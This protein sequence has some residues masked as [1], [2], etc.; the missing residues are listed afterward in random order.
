MSRISQWMS[1]ICQCVT[2]SARRPMRSRRLATALALLLSAITLLP[3]AAR[4][5][6]TD[7]PASCTTTAGFNEDTATAGQLST[8]GILKVPL[9]STT[10]LPGGGTLYTFDVAAGLV[11][12]LPATPPGFNGLTATPAEQAA[13]GIP[14][15][16]PSSEAAAY[17]AW[18]TRVADWSLNPGGSS[19]V[20]LYAYGNRNMVYTHGGTGCGCWSGY[21]NT[22]T[23][24]TL[25][26]A[27]YSEPG[28]TG[29]CGGGQVGI[30]SGIGGLTDNN[31]GQT[32]TEEGRPGWPNGTLWY[33]TDPSQSSP[34][35][36]FNGAP[37]AP[38][39]SLVVAITQ[40]TGGRYVFTDYVNASEYVAY[41]SGSNATW[42]SAD[43]TAEEVVE[44]LQG[45]EITNFGRFTLSGYNGLGGSPVGSHATDTFTV[46][47]GITLGSLPNG[48]ASFSEAWNNCVGYA[49]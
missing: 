13:Y 2:L 19:G 37:S 23:G 10:S 45:Q 29:S 35:M 14:P 11:V 12:S 15:A 1:R 40:W 47:P 9:S 48:A 38:P 30:W 5:A 26:E 4:A 31:F 46:S 44:N 36:Q 49:T 3:A 17:S 24:W 21:G 25:A 43:S 33:E 8:C 39:G 34:P 27:S 18:E 6:D 42:S 20:P 22:P 16:P 32:G 28:D 7:V 41:A